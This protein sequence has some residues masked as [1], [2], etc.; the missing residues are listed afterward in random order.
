MIKRRTVRFAF[1]TIV[2]NRDLLD[3]RLLVLAG[4]GF[5]ASG[6]FRWIAS[7]DLADNF[8]VCWIAA[9]GFLC[10][11]FILE[12]LLRSGAIRGSRDICNS[13]GLWFRSLRSFLLLLLRRSGSC[14]C[15]CAHTLCAEARLLSLR[16]LRHAAC[17]R[18]QR[19]HPCHQGWH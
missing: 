19:C 7:H 5:W 13:G 18:V 10:R 11:S 17:L 12:F 14:I 2:G 3:Y 15:S 1:F 8:Y 6:C 4:D 9:D 16:P